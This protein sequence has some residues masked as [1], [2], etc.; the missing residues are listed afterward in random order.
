[1]AK[2]RINFEHLDGISM[3]PLDHKPQTVTITNIIVGKRYRRDLGDIAALT[4][5]IEQD[6]LLQPIV[7][8]PDGTLISG[9]RRLAAC[10]T[11]GLQ[12]IPVNVVPLDKIARG[13]FV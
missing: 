7:I 11:A 3:K 8:R 6:G 12:D 5:T 10:K 1:M 2:I 4:Q 13:E 9:A